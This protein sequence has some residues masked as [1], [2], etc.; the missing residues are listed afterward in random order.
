MYP[1]IVVSLTK[2]NTFLQKGHPSNSYNSIGLDG[3]FLKFF[4]FP[5]TKA[6]VPSLIKAGAPAVA[7]CAGKTV[8]RLQKSILWLSGH[9]LK[10]AFMQ[11][12][13]R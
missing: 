9:S 3:R 11:K 1:C 8:R 5:E 13:Y 7:V 10:Q 4:R 6:A 2:H 12:L